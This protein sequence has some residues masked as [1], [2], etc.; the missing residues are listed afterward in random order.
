MSNDGKKFCVSVDINGG[1]Y[2]QQSCCTADELMAAVALW[3]A[4]TQMEENAEYKVTV[5]YGRWGVRVEV[6]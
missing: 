1:E 5:K 3:N 4:I 2:M 6:E